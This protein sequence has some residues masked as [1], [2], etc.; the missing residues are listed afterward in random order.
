MDRK[1][2]LE[3]LKKVKPGIADKA[4]VESM[5]Y[6]YFSGK[7]V[8]TYNDKISVLHPLKTDFQ[9]FVQAEKLYKIVSLAKATT[10]K[11]TEKENSLNIRTSTINVD[12]T[13]ILDE[14]ITERINLISKSI[15]GVKWKK[16]PSNFLESAS[17]CAFAASKLDAEQIMSCLYFNEKECMATDNDR[18]AIAPIEG[19]IDTMF[20]KASQITNLRD[21]N[22]DK[23]VVTKAWVHFKNEEGC[24]FS[25]R[26]IEGTFPEELK[27]AFD[28]DGTTVTLSE[29]IL[30]G[31]DLASIFVDSMEPTITIRITKGMCIVSV[32]SDGGGSK[33]RSKVDYDGTDIVFTLN[34]EFLKEMLKHSTTIVIDDDRSRAK[35]SAG[36]FSMLTSLMQNEV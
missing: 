16:L 1:K 9:L 10:L 4:I 20:F 24:I 30:E 19:K 23:Y 8:V 26:R 28:F 17:M 29:N 7:E 12:L 18:F 36:D 5:M 3:V 27:D 31:T 14:E 35:L 13:T 15:S 21:I 34:P 22:P 11:M 32:T 25:I 33:H 2:L 6:F